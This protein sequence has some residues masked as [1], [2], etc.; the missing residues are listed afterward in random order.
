M[1]S[2][3]SRYLTKGVQRALKLEVQI[4]LWSLI[5]SLKEP[6]DYLQVFNLRKLPDGWINVEHS[7]EEPEYFSE[8]MIELPLDEENLKVFVIDSGEYS[9][10][11]LDYEY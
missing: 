9:T 11:L 10:M 6:K 2:K 5:D 7:Q 3:N 8:T 1:F 4:Y